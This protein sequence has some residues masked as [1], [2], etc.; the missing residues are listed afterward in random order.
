[1]SITKTKQWTVTPNGQWEGLKCI[2]APIKEIGPKDCLVKIDAVSLNYRDVAIPMGTYPLASRDGVVPCSDGA[3]AV[4]AV[5]ESTSRFK[6]GDRVCT[7]FN[8]AY[9]TGTTSREIRKYALG[10]LLDGTLR[11]YAIFPETALVA[12]PANLNMIEASTLSC[13]AVTVWNCLFGLSD[14]ALKPGDW[15]LTQ[16]TG[17]VSLFAIQIALALGANVISTTSSA[18][19]IESLKAM[20][21][22]HIINYKEDPN[23]GKTAKSLTPGEE[24]VH[25]VVEVGGEATMP[26]SLEAIRVEGVISMV[27]FL[28]GKKNEDS[29]TFGSI[30]STL[31][32]VRGINVGPVEQFEAC[33]AFIEKH[34]IKP[35]VDPQPFEFSQAPEAL[36]YLWEQKNYGKVVIRLN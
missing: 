22:K 4:I 21:V 13:A 2:E 32:I 30:L 10:T 12:A 7:A 20:G 19:K 17:G 24:G 33:N 6:V 26:Q 15:V 27:G 31:A 8:Q 29:A 36:K 3:G 14:R 23:W 35:I 25:H 28:S 9:F 5:G 1:M 11:E 18:K 16:G 34:D